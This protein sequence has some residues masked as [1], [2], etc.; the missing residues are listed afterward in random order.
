MAGEGSI[1]Q[2][3]EWWIAQVSTG[4]RGQRRYL[5]RKRRRRSEAVTALAELQADRRAGVTRSRST[6]GDYLAG[7]VATVRNLRPS[8]QRG[9]A[10]AIEL[11]LVPEIGAIRLADLSPIDVERMLARLAG[12]MSPKHLRNVHAVLRKALA[13]ARRHGMVA[14]NVAASEYVDAPRVP[15]EEPASFTAAE[16]ARL[17]AAADG[18]RIETPLRLALGTGLRQGELLGLAWEDIDLDGG[19]LHVRREL[20]RRDGTYHREELKTGSRSRRVLPLAPALVALLSVHL[21]AIRD[22][23]LVPISTGPVFVTAAGVPL[24]GSSL[25]HRL[26]DLE[27][28]AGVRR[29]P[30]K[31]LR[32]TFASRLFEAGVPDRVIADWLGHTRRSTTHGHY[33]DTANGSQERA[34]AAVGGLL[35]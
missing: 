21:D 17:L 3:G 6:T 1:Y 9:Y 16:V 27:A 12:R 24:N 4:G 10:T 2:S 32:T 25:T 35:G 33:I 34:L 18:D 8:T 22:A 14:R 7:W 28:A 13:D 31:N 11:H 5:R 23:G 15:D 20:V 29:L 30:W 19:R 26:Y